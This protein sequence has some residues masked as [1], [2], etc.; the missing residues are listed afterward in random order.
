MI[1]ELR[2]LLYL[3]PNAH[4][5][6]YTKNTVGTLEMSRQLLPSGHDPVTAYG[7][8][9]MTPWQPVAAVTRD[10][11]SRDNDLSA[12]T[13]WQPVAAVTRD[14]PSKDLTSQLLPGGHDPVTAGG[15]RDPGHV[16]KGPDVTVRHHRNI[17]ALSE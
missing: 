4:E 16:V 3:P 10:T 11:S 17:H 12:M 1:G 15:S 8:R 14:T 2:L 13:P 9:A 6:L 7:S 5:H